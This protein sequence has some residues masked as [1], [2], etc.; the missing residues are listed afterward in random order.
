M[1]LQK[2]WTVQFICR[3]GLV[4]SHP[5]SEF[6]RLARGSSQWAEPLQMHDQML[7]IPPPPHPPTKA[8]SKISKWELD[9]VTYKIKTSG[10][11]ALSRL[12]ISFLGEASKLVVTLLQSEIVRFRKS[13]A[14]GF[15]CKPVLKGS[16]RIP[17]TLV[18]VF[19]YY[20]LP[21]CMAQS[22][23]IKGQIFPRFFFF[24]F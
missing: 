1:H 12:Y 21:Y 4:G 19:S 18:C 2:L 10:Q 20:V 16:S 17:P 5:V 3:C 23:I 15:F 11:K 9:F 22:V 8:L 24:L 14:S 13:C 7:K 6:S